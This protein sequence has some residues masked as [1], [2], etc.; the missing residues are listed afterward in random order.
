MEDDA[1]QL[2]EA[3][4]SGA[5]T[6]ELMPTRLSVGPTRVLLNWRLEIGNEGDGHIVA[7][8][9]RSDMVCAHSSVPSVEQLGAPDPEARLHTVKQLA[10]GQSENILGEWQ[11]P[12]EDV[13]TIE[14][15]TD[16]ILVLLGRVQ[17]VGAGIPPTR[18]AFVIGQ[19][20]PATEA[21]LRG[22]ALSADMQIH[23]KLA[24]KAIL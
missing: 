15:E 22:I 24:A 11:L 21:K 18:H 2:E 1:D 8:R 16:T 12:R 19:P 3:I 13:K 23:S 10:P 7:L 5:L 4:A 20:A 6:L 9:L 17:C 14:S